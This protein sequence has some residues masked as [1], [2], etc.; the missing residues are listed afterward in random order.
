MTESFDGW[1][2]GWY[3]DYLNYLFERKTLTLNSQTKPVIEV[4]PQVLMLSKVNIRPMTIN[5]SMYV[6]ELV[7]ESLEE[8]YI[9]IIKSYTV[10]LINN[11]PDEECQRMTIFV[12]RAFDKDINFKKQSFIEIFDIMNK[13][14]K[15]H[16]NAIVGHNR[17]LV[18]S[19]GLPVP[20]KSE[21]VVKALGNY[22]FKT[23]YSAMIMDARTLD[24]DFLTKDYDVF[25]LIR[26]YSQKDMDL[27]DF[28]LNNYE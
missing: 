2:C 10:S 24:S 19:K 4:G 11:K 25:K 6:F 13:C 7:K 28:Y 16:F 15:Q 22:Q 20:D 26:P 1:L 14:K 17:E 3:Q 9:P 12:K 23:R 5:K 8:K 27:I 21:V 18:L